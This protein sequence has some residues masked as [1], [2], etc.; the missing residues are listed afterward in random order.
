[1]YLENI[2]NI[3]FVQRQVPELSFLERHNPRVGRGFTVLGYISPKFR[4]LHFWSSYHNLF[5]AT[6]S[7]VVLW[8]ALQS[9]ARGLPIAFH[10]F[11]QFFQE[12]AD[13]L[14]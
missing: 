10:G 8:L 5:D 4:V 1:M 12:N 9:K 6:L 7:V 3:K 11:V 2:L 14:S 13:M